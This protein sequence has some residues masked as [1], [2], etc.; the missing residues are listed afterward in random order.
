MNFSTQ[1]AQ[2]S[3]VRAIQQ[4]RHN[5]HIAA[6]RRSDLTSVDLASSALKHT[7][8]T[9]EEYMQAIQHSDD[10]LS[11]NNVLI[12]VRVLI[13]VSISKHG[14]I[15]NLVMLCYTQDRFNAAFKQLVS[16]Q[17]SGSEDCT[18]THRRNVKQ[19]RPK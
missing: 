2:G 13:I 6:D 12:G 11:P 7:M 9:M 19:I 15:V 4:Y 3:L 18:L 5:E 8:A 10:V 1:Q 14:I 17:K 16:S